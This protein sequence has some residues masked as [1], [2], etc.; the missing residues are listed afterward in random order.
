MA[1]PLNIKSFFKFLGRNKL[2]T[3][4]N[5]IGLSLSLMFVIIIG[6][7][8]YQETTVD[9]WQKNK[10][11]MYVIG[12]DDNMGTANGLR[13]YMI[14]RYPEIEEMCGV[15]PVERNQLTVNGAKQYA[16]LMY[17]DSTFF[18]L[19]T[20]R[21]LDG[22]AKALNSASH[23]IV[24]ES[25]ARRIAG[26]GSAIGAVIAL[27]DY[28]TVTVA[29]VMEDIEN[30]V[31]KYADVIVPMPNLMKPEP[32]KEGLNSLGGFIQFILT[33]EGVDFS[34]RETEITEY[35]H[36][37]FW[38]FQRGWAEKATV[39]PFK[40]I[41]FSDIE[42]DGCLRQGNKSLLNILLAVALVILVF[43][44]LN[45]INLTVAQTGF[46]AREMA[47]RELLGASQRE[48]FAKFIL[49]SICMCGV[50]FVI[51]LLLAGAFQGI[52]G[53]MLQSEINVWES[54]SFGMAGVFVVFIML[55]GALAGIIPAVHIT[56]YK[57]I[58]V[59]RGTFR[60]RSKMVFGKVFITFQN[61]IT[62]TLIA[63][64]LTIML[65]IRHMINM[66]L[67]YNTENIL[68]VQMWDIMEREREMIGTFRNEVEN[69]ASVKRLSMSSGHPFNGGN[70]N[71]ME[72]NGKD[73]S[74]QIFQAD[75]VFMDMMGIQILKDYRLSTTDGYWITER[76]LHEQGLPE[77]AEY[78]F[79]YDNKPAIRGIV[80]EF[81]LRDAFYTREHPILIKVLP[82]DNSFW[83][84][85]IEVQGDP[86]A[87]Y[88][89]I[90][91][92]YETLSEREFEASYL[93]DQIYDSYSE[94]HKVYR[95]IAMFTVIAVL[96]SMLGL[97][98][99]STYYIQQRSSEIA[100]RKVFGSSRGE[101]FERLVRN[102]LRLVLIAFMIA[103]PLIWY[104][105]GQWLSQ[106]PYR[107]NLSPWI[108]LAAGALAL[109]IAS[110][111][112]MWQSARAANANPI[113]S[114]HKD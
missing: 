1:N 4:I 9:S 99:M 49:E 108:F 41:Y 5:I 61:V 87:A 98:A 106:F 37:F 113:D 72:H 29:A 38:I 25:F 35:F 47:T 70:N 19:F 27:E 16:D 95:L 76:V 65:Q 10:D 90:K 3:A 55:L 51:G 23:A 79:L 44:V 112:V 66:P 102:F 88:N 15:Y 85:L 100:T 50:A 75:S 11:R 48:I 26:D 22:D 13:Q 93:E 6:L 63:C 39:V 54:I 107:I 58:D 86:T 17:T 67:G 30:S 103:I 56:R 40:E 24:S 91:E 18:D 73:V 21:I 60:Q 71:T 32:W 92:L 7:Y 83:G 52:I 68:Y 89:E 77:D 69:L 8:A 12:I 2:Y 45:Y 36:S 28:Y 81:K 64:S 101:V 62:I 14:D 110:V 82:R 59:V 43:A 42:G 80:R 46:R 109:L 74:F 34:S 94:Q 96:I 105:M 84:M 53:N 20:F 97:L 57:A 33:K 111:T 31:I 114:L 78:F 104:F